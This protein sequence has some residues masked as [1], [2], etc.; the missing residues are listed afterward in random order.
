MH[1]SIPAHLES[2]NANEVEKERN[3]ILDGYSQI[4]E[5]W[6]VETSKDSLTGWR[7]AAIAWQQGMGAFIY[8]NI[9]SFHDSFHRAGQRP[10]EDMASINPR[11]YHH[12]CTGSDSVGSGSRNNVW[13]PTQYRNYQ[14][15]DTSS[16]ST[17]KFIESGDKD[18]LPLCRCPFFLL[19]FSKQLARVCIEGISTMEAAG[20][21]ATV[22]SEHW[23]STCSFF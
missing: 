17:L 10:G 19:G 12:T 7:T 2:R 3:M 1:K 22:Q 6:M 13:S 15:T 20:N 4:R 16:T 9:T 18:L 23:N 8:S 5:R 21:L 11:A 14:H